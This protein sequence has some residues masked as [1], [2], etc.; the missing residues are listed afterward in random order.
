MFFLDEFYKGIQ[1]REL[2]NSHPGFR[3]FAAVG[4]EIHPPLGKSF[5]NSLGFAQAMVLFLLCMCISKCL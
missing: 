3:V 5:D 2:D 4:E 1:V